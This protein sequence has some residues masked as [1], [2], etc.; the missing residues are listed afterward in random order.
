[1]LTLIIGSI[2]K[3]TLNPDRRKSFTTTPTLIIKRS[4]VRTNPTII[5]STIKKKEIYSS[6]KK[7]R[8]R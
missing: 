7:E 6:H 1:M 2:L 4:T 5:L 8:V 3:T